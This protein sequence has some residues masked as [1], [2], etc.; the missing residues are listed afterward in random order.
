MQLFSRLE[1]AGGG[2]A[3]LLPRGS[4]RQGK[5]RGHPAANPD[6]RSQSAAVLYHGGSALLVIVDMPWRIV[7][8]WNRST[9]GLREKRSADAANRSRIAKN[10][11][12]RSWQPNF[13]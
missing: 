12:Q 8:D 11:G 5:R 3:R 7:K 1:R 9:A 13:T 10:R 4:L 6:R 2:E